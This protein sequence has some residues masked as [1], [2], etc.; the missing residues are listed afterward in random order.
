MRLISVSTLRDFWESHPDAREPLQGWCA[1]V[2][3]ARWTSMDDIVRHMPGRPSPV[4]GDRVV[5]NIKGNR[6]RL[7]AYIDF[8]RAVVL[9]KFI[10]THDE[11]DAVDVT[12]V[13]RHL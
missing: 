8:R 5:F 6:Y 3:A 13:D 11:Y 12:T 4:S 2:K 10:G 1:L 9:V 7:I